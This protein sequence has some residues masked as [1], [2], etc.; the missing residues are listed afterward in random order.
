[1]TMVKT[2]EEFREELRVLREDLYQNI[3]AADLKLIAS[4][5]DRL[6]IS[7]E[8][9]SETLELTDTSVET[10]A[11][12]EKPGKGDICTCPSCSEAGVV[13]RKTA[14]AKKAK[15]PKKARKAKSAKK[16]RR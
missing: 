3:G 14:K 10:L 2:T 8:G 5:L 7:L 1:M 4:Y 12:A 11:E 16:K 9:L 15:K 6:I 13:V